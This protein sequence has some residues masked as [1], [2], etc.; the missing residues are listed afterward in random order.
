MNH[1]PGQ[2]QEHVFGNHR[3]AGCH[4]SRFAHQCFPSR[5]AVHRI[6][7]E[8]RFAFAHE[9]PF[10]G[11]ATKE[12]RRY[13]S[14]QAPPTWRALINKVS[15][16]QSSQIDSTCCTWPDVAPLCH[17]PAARPRKEMRLSGG[18]RFFQSRFV[19]PGHHQNVSVLGILH[20]RRD[21]SFIVPF[22]SGRK[23]GEDR[24]QLP[25]RSRLLSHRCTQLQDIQS[26]RMPFDRPIRTGETPSGRKQSPA[27]ESAR[28]PSY[29]TIVRNVKSAN[30]IG[31]G[32]AVS[33][34]FASGAKANP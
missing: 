2:L 33:A 9:L 27:H 21:Q 24:K 16:S 19:H 32:R 10:G 30:L 29:L 22:Q 12:A 31:P 18:E 8:E 5:R 15:P 20:D 26:N 28:R 11:D 14:W 17:E 13:P 3:G 6:W 7:V 25:Q 1:R 23:T 4:Q 34:E